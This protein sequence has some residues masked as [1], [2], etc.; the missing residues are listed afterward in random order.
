MGK[1]RPL[2]GVTKKKVSEDKVSKHET[3]HKRSK[4]HNVKPQE[5]DDESSKG[6]IE[7]EGGV[8]LFQ[9]DDENA[10]NNETL[11]KQEKKQRKRLREEALERLM[12]NELGPSPTAFRLHTETGAERRSENKHAKR[13][14]QSQQIIKPE[15][16]GVHLTE[17]HESSDCEEIFM[18]DV[19]PSPANRDK[20]HAQSEDEDMEDGG[21]L[22]P[23]YT[24]PPSGSNRA[25][26]RR[27][28]LI[29]KEKARIQ[30]N[31]GVKEGSDEKAKEMQQLLN[32]FIE[33]YDSKTDQREAK[34]RER[35]MKESARLR[36]LRG[37]ASERHFLKVRHKKTRGSHNG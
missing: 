35:K 25:V 19:N 34:K 24:A 16:A 37:K 5:S 9:Y 27:A 29:D 14:Q 30:R 7:E 13:S 6:S 3:R 20:L 8:S 4:W 31:L 18:I 17:V 12:E 26:R 1:E 22:L 21:A 15:E 32:N 10:A 36:S 33:T 2:L 28:N 11:A 23:G